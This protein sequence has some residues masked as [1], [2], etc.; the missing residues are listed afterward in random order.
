M[1]QDPVCGMTVNQPQ[2]ANKSN[3]H[4]TDYFFCSS[5]CKEKFDRNPA[6]FVHGGSAGQP[7]PAGKSSSRQG[8][9]TGQ[10]QPAGQQGTTGQQGGAG[11]QQPSAQQ[12]ATGGRQR[13]RKSA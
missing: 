2:E 8:A 11:Q 12:G 6:Q 4:G 3:Y 9:G 5:Q 1:N 7:H 13:R 10:H